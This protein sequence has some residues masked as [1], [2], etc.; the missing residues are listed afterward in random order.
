MRCVNDAMTHYPV[1]CARLDG[2]VT[3]ERGAVADT[4]VI[5]NIFLALWQ[6]EYYFSHEKVAIVI[7]CV[8]CCVV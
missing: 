1:V 7:C 8:T 6:L 5:V 2:D 3:V 4:T